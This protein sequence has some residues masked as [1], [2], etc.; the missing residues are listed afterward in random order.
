VIFDLGL[1]IGEV[2]VPAVVLVTAVVHRRTAG[3]R[4]RAGPQRVVR[5]R[6]QDLVAVVEERLERHRD[7]LGHPVADVDVVDDRVRQS[8]G[9]VVLRDGGAGG[10]DA[11]RVGVAL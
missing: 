6:H 1:D 10:V 3:Q 2:R 4:D 9:L 7:Q 11:A 5:R 8:A